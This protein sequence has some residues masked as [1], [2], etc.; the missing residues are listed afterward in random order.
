MKTVIFCDFDGTVT[1]RDVGYTMFHH[2]SN[3]KNDELMPDWK[4][5]ALSSRDCLLRE[6]EM[7]HAT[8]DEIRQYLNGFEIQ[9]GFAEFAEHCR[10]SE[11]E[12]VI[13]S[14]GLDLYIDHLLKRDKISGFEILSNHGRVEGRR[15]VVE[16]PHK[17][18]T[19]PRCGNCKGERIEEFRARHKEEY[20]VVFIGDGYSDVCATG[21][22]DIIFAK[23]DLEQYCV[24][25]NI[26]Y[27]R[28]H[29]FFDVTRQLLA[30]RFLSQPR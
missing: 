12:L 23:K 16:F 29:D 4:S 14:D 5:G 6:A 8:E 19:C 15:M 18:H 3:G 28:Y 7:I 25:S 24:K 11:T 1:R 26:A 17:N 13:V 20:R 21:V 10:R 30:W 27:Y 2:F 9:D 22:A